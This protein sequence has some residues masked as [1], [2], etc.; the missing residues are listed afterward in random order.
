LSS[1][2]RPAPCL[3]RWRLGPAPLP[4]HAAS[5]SSPSPPLLV[6]LASAA[7]VGCRGWSGGGSISAACCSSSSPPPPAGRAAPIPSSSGKEPYLACVVDTGSPRAARLV[8]TWFC[9]F[10]CEQTTPP[11]RRCFALPTH[12]A[13]GSSAPW[14]G[15]RLIQSNPSARPGCCSLVLPLPR[16]AFLRARDRFESD[17][18]G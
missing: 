14:Y 13:A 4:E 11:T 7:G 9:C 17:P 5:N 8:K 6:F 15:A 16:L 10:E 12:F 18:T 1:P 3:S 2:C